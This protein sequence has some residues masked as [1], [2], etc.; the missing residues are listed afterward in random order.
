MEYRKIQ[1]TGEGTYII[2]LPKK[3]VKKNQLGKKDVISVI[4]KDDELLLRLKEKKEQET[5]IKINT[6]DAEFL[7]M[8]L[9]TK[10][11]QGYDTIIFTSKDYINPEIRKK[12]IKSSTYL[13]GLEPFGETKNQLTFK[14][15]MKERGQLIESAQRMHDMSL[16]SFT[17]LMDDLEMEAYN[18][19]ILDGIIQRDDEIDKFYFLIL[20]QLST[21]SGFEATVWVQIAKSIERISDHIEQIAILTKE[22]KR[23]KKEDIKTYKEMIDMYKGVILALKNENPPLANDILKKIQKFRLMEKKNIHTIDNSKG[24]CVLF[25]ESFR[26]IRE[27][28]SDI[29]ES[30]INLS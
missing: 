7:S 13:I 24:Q 29:A 15:F 8:S 25:Y 19:N 23:M 10:Y 4:E 20:R 2:S 18:E 11:I 28:I 27:Y 30:V 6:K 16:L 1:V 12:L 14:M 21:L 9:I 26:R 5:E 3:W 17:E 22:C